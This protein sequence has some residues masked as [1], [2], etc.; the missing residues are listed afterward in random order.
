MNQYQDLPEFVIEKC[1]VKLSESCETS[2]CDHATV[3]SN[4]ETCCFKC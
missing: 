4:G 1:D 3:L 2:N